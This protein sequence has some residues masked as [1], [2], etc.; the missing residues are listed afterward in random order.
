MTAAF[1]SS[2]WIKST[3]VGWILGVVFI[4]VFSG[5]LESVGIH[6]MQFYLGFSMGL[7]VGLMQWFYLRKLIN[8]NLRWMFFSALGLSI[9]FFI[10]DLLTSVVIPHKLVVCI[11][12]GAVLSGFFQYFLLKPH[13]NKTE[14]WI[15]TSFLGWTLSAALVFLMDY[16][17]RLRDYHVANL[18]L[19]LINFTLILSG[20]IVLGSISAVSLKKMIE[21]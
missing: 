11:G 13:F 12:L 1:N 14:H 3:F 7:G 15:I 20:G 16:T 8:V 17:W 4:L 9:P 5:A 10:F 19:A 18:W 21:I 2:K 6:H